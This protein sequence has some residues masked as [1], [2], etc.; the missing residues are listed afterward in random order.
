MDRF[1]KAELRGQTRNF[2]NLISKP[3]FRQNYLTPIRTLPVEDQCFLLQKVIDHTL[4]LAEMK[5]EAAEMKKMVILRKAF[6]QCTNSR[7]W[8][9][10]KEKFPFYATDSQL[11]RFIRVDVQKEVPQSFMDFCRRATG[12]EAD[13]DPT[14][15]NS[16]RFNTAVGFAIDSKISE[17]SAHKI[18]QSFSRF[19]GAKL[20][21]ISCNEVSINDCKI[22]CSQVCRGLFRGV[23]WGS[24]NPKNFGLQ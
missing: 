19:F 10:A 5:T 23:S 18:K 8:E 17:L 6:V 24:G 20:G 14:D 3:E 9:I 4:S 12:E 2:S 7:T 21:I 22:V 13:H 16:V 1:E 11:K 15:H